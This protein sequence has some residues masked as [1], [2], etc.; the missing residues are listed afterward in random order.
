MSYH[1]ITV[2]DMESQK[3]TEY[4][5]KK[6][7]TADVCIDGHIYEVQ[8][9]GFFPLREKIK[10][11]MYN[12]DY[13]VTVVAPIAKIKHLC[14]IDPVCGHV[15]TRRRSPK[16]GKVQDLAKELYWI[17]ELITD[18]KYSSRLEIK[19]M[20]LE[21]EEYRIK[22][23]WGNDGKRGSNRYDK[24]PISLMSVETLGNATD[25]AKHF[26]TDTLVSPFTAA[27]YTR[28]TTIRGKAAYS[29]LH[30]LEEFG[31]IKRSEKIGR[32]QGYILKQSE[33]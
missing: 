18:P 10:W 13:A 3:C 26:L 17:S 23:G 16:T 29:A 6:K 30:I 1:E 27:D 28:A 11:Y 5:Q 15:S 4:A 20:L 25:Y 31:L 7:I 12:T 14:W 19:V 21:I 2:A 22:D 32:A 24:I 8:T 9:G 33:Q